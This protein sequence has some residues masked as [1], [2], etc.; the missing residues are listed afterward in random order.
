MT[1][2]VIPDGGTIGSASDTDAL[3]I[4]NTG[5]VKASQSIATSTIKDA[6]GT[7]NSISIATNGEATFA[8]NIILTA[9]KG[10]SFQNH[11]VSS[12]TGASSTTS[13]NVLDD[14]EEGTW[15][16]TFHDAVSGGNSNTA[17]LSVGKY[18]KIGRSV[19]CTGYAININTSGL[20]GGNALYMNLPFT[21]ASDTRFSGSCVFGLINYY[22]ARGWVSIFG[23]NANID[24]LVFQFSR[25]NMS[26]VNITCN[27]LNTGSAS[28]S[29]IHA[30][31]FHYTV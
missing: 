17:S 2:I 21:T 23:D 9:N 20:T 3:T 8:E 14:Y 19:F 28:S 16:V 6:T 27:M 15:N 24:R 30:F 11:S 18:T 12:A 31:S 29:D 26:P 13:D 22:D 10:L 4:T 25:R 5:V 7:N 1:G